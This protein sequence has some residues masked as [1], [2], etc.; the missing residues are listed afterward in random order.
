MQRKLDELM[1]YM[2][3]LEPYPVGSYIIKVTTRKKVL[4]LPITKLS[5]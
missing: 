2:L 1:N 5:H 3:D 4:S